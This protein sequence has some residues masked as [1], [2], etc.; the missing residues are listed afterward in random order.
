MSRLKELETITE[1]VARLEL[2]ARSMAEKI[3]REKMEEHKQK[4]VAKQRE[5]ESLHNR[6]VSALEVL[7][8]E[9]HHL[10]EENER[11]KQELR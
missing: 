6:A 2:Q 9:K 8:Q 11:L 4:E 5:V 3:V 7:I 10:R 1:V